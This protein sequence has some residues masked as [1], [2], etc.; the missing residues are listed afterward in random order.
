MACLFQAKPGYPPGPLDGGDQKGGKYPS[1]DAP[2]PPPTE[3]PPE[4]T[5][6]ALAATLVDN[7]PVNSLVEAQSVTPVA[8]NK[9]RRVLKQEMSEVSNVSIT[10]DDPEGMDRI[11]VQMKADAQ[12]LLQVK[13]EPKE[14]PKKATPHGPCSKA[15][16]KTIKRELSAGSKEAAQSGADTYGI[17]WPG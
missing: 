2:L 12:K 5:P 15:K 11:L 13:K 3:P 16:T 17:F 1:E 14:E 6:S 4:Q 7:K 9:K 8:E 10:A